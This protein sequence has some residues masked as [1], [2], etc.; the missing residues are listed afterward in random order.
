MSLD[1]TSEVIGMAIL[2][3]GTVSDEISGTSSSEDVSF[4][5]ADVENMSEDILKELDENQVCLSLHIT[6]NQCK[7]RKKAIFYL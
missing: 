2:P 7:R 5:E 1:E 4:D 6:L 3:K